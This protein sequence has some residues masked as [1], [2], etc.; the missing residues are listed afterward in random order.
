MTKASLQKSLLIHLFIILI[1]VFIVS[2]KNN[3]TKDKFSFSLVEKEAIT[4]QKKPKININATKPLR[5][6]KTLVKPIREV[7]GI[8][9]KSQV[10][11]N[12]KVKVKLGNNLNKKE[13]KK[14]L[15]KDDPD[16]LPQATEEFL[17]T[18]M[19]RAIREVRPEYP[20][21]AKEQKISGR[22]IFEILIDG[23]GDVRK[24][25]LVKGLH[26]ELD[27][28]AQKAIVRFKFKPAYMK[29]ESTAVRIK[30]AIRYVLEN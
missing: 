1:F 8:N 5:V 17:I 3:N 21:W 14:V 22:V 28:L 4:I 29:T 9:R 2:V 27:K 15:K 26:P 30:Y 18:S 6:K 10:S 12:G 7:F 16:S 11:P 13:D 25:I 23:K 20:R 24:A 19:P